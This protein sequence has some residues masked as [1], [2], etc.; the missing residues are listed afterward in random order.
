MINQSPLKP[1]TVHPTVKELC[2][3]ILI[4]EEGW[5]NKAYPDPLTQG[6]PWTIGVGHTGPEVVQGLRW[7]DMQIETA[8]QIDLD[9]AINDSLR[10]WPWL[11]LMSPARQAV[12]ICM[13]FQMGDGRLAK[14]ADTLA[15]MRRGLYE[16]ASNSMEDS[17]W[18]RQTPL[19]AA[20]M[21]EL[22][23]KG[24]MTNV[25]RSYYRRA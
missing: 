23:Q 13:C 7:N 15:F 17:K 18:A 8:F 9:E 11:T 22:M 2:H 3:S 19:R 12:L 6:D 21:V 5:E 4:V 25:L 24:E 1:L 20:R 14:F 10:K 16:S